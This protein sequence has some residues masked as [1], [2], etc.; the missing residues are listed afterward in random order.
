VVGFFV[1]LKAL[2]SNCFTGDKIKKQTLIKSTNNMKN[3]A[4]FLLLLAGFA[5]GCRFK[6]SKDND[7]DDT[8]GSPA[9]T[10]AHAAGNSVYN[11]ENEAGVKTAQLNLE[12]GAMVVNLTNGTE[13]LFNA[14]VNDTTRKFV[15]TQKTTVSAEEVNFILKEH[16]HKAHNDSASAEIRLST[17]PQ[18]DIKAKV[19]AAQCD[20][21]LSRFKISK[22][23]LDCAAGELKLKLPQALP[24]TYVEIKAAIAD[25][26]VLI[27]KGVA[28][29]V[30][31]GSAIAD[32]D[33][34]GFQKKDDDHYETPGFAS[35]KN[36]IHIKSNCTLSSFKI[37]WY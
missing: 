27:P 9:S 10:V 31:I 6:T 8:I 33:L 36:K 18:W 16:E 23:G 24:D 12:A 11:L 22:L 20:F 17:Q 29:E 28:C 5:V 25:I 21:D 35:A 7:E 3:K 37:D 26:T 19:G 2:S 1:P 14:I 30:Q 13:K 4:L 15:L 34:F 32:N